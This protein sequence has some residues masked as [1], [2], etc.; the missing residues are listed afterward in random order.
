MIYIDEL[1][2]GAG[3][4]GLAAGQH[5][6]EMG[7]EYLIIERDKQ[8][9]GLCSSY[10]T[11]GFVFDYFI[12][13]SFTTN[14]TVRKYFDKTPHYV[15]T[16]NPYNYY[17]GMWI[18]H[19]AINNLCPLS[20][21]EKQL[22][23]DGLSDRNKYSD[24]Y[25]DNYEMW[26]RYQFG[27]Y[28]AEHF[29]LVYT[30]KYWSVEAKNM[31]TAWVGDRIYHPAMD[32][33]KS[34]MNT[35]DTP[36]TY[37]AKEM[38]Y[39]VEGGYEKYL[40]SF[41]NDSRIALDEEVISIDLYHKIV[42]TDRNEY[43]YYRLYSS[44]PL[45]ELKVLLLNQNMDLSESIDKLHWTSGYLVSLGLK[46]N[47]PRA[48][49]WDYI[50]DEDI[51]VSRYYSPSEMSE[52]SAPDGCYSIQA[53]IYTKDGKH[54]ILSEEELLEKTIEQL[55]CIGAIRKKDITVKDIRFR[56]YC[57]IIFDQVT[58]TARKKIL[59]LTGKNGMIS[60]GRFGTWEYFW[61]DQSFMSGYN[62]V[63]P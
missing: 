63:Q 49:L 7:K 24:V 30:R 6:E 17:H 14:E 43:C 52:K 1:I 61:S 2:L 27:D 48:E 13:M 10:Q 54:H 23:L 55:D 21:A 46:G 50:Y 39:P 29:P 28:F 60:I 45:P 22:V 34:G 35:S 62:A 51:V 32:E 57:N 3:I 44:I 36:V 20:D 19:P 5:L 40:S 18:K 41:S 56:K 25:T 53:E 9:G 16:P 31:G 33:I 42:K 15:H 4:A 59:D 12:H 11:D 58:Y 47:N 26:L 8:Y 37:Y 38:R